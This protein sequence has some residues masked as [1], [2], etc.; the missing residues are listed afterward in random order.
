MKSIL[1]K[2]LLALAGTAIFASPAMAAISMEPGSLAIAFYQTDASGTAVGSNTY[3]FD[4]GQASLYR[5]STLGNV[6][7]STINTG[8]SGN[9][10]ADLASAFGPDWAESGTVR[11]AIVGGVGSTDPT[12]S[13]DPARTSYISRSNSSY[14]VGVVGSGSTI[15]NVSS[16]NRGFLST[17]IDSFFAGTDAAAQTTG[18]NPSGSIILSSAV[19][20]IEDYLPPTTSGLYFGQGIDPR[21]VL[22]AGTIDGTTEGALDVYRV[23]HSAN[24]ADLTA[25]NSD[26]AAV[27]GQGQYVGT[28]TLSTNGDI[29]FTGAI[30]EPS[31]ALLLGIASTFACFGYR[32]RSA[33][34][35]A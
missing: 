1:N 17:N 32:R 15:A 11:W 8:L 3:V 5:E 14:T 23:L 21:Q 7:V 16:N 30:P 28:F 22:G 31:S 6:S 9:I 13:G 33:V 24:G 20:S 18:A 4:L 29:G 25:G 35:T 27:V 12:T 19:N 10:G 26:V 2:G 34:R